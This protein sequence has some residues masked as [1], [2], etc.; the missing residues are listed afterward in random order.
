MGRANESPAGA[1]SPNRASVNVFADGA[2]LITTPSINSSL[3]GRWLN[4]R[5]GLPF[6]TACTVAAL[7][8]L[9]AGHGQ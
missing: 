2:E 9:G 1:A 6:P 3:A 5:F 4:R 7:A 8:G